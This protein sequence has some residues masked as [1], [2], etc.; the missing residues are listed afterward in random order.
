M[1]NEISAYMSALGAS[2][3]PFEKCTYAGDAV[4]IYEKIV[5][6]DEDCNQRIEAIRS[7]SHLSGAM[8]FQTTMC[9]Q[10]QP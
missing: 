8:S 9:D 7:R 6:F 2:S 4:S 5:K 10:N 1:I 3:D